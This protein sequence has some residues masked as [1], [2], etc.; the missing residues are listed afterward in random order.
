MSEGRVRG[1]WEAPGASA[2]IKR[3]TAV[4]RAPR[5]SGLDWVWFFTKA[6]EQSTAPHP[7]K[8]FEFPLAKCT[9]ACT[10]S[11]AS[12]MWPAARGPSKTW[13]E[14]LEAPEA[15]ETR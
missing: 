10:A 9:G 13:L 15:R 11:S 8:K 5:W 4:F 2:P 6:I 7:Q 1:E 12:V 3:N 14:A